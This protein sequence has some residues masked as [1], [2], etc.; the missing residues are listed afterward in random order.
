[1]KK[2]LAA[3]LF[4]IATPVWAQVDTVSNLSAT[5]KT[6]G[7]TKFWSEAKYNFVY[8]DKTKINWDSAYTAYLPQVLATKS[9][10]DY[11]NVLKKFCALLQ[12]GHTNVF[13]P[14]NLYKTSR[15]RQ[16]LIENFDQHFFVTNVGKESSAKEIIGSEVISINNQP[17]QIWLKN[18]II[19]YISASTEHQRWN[20]A[21]RM[22]FVDTDTTKTWQLKLKTLKGKQID[23]QANWHTY[24]QNWYQPIPQW[25]RFQYKKIGDVGYLQINTFADTAI[26]GD[27]RKVL[28]ELYTC[29]AIIIDLRKN[30][31]GNS[32]IGADLLK[33]FTTEKNIVGSVWKTRD[34][35]AAFNAWG[36]AVLASNPQ[37]DI[38]T[39]SNFR[40]KSVQVAQGNYWFQ[41]DTMQFENNLAVKR[42]EQPLVVL[43]SNNTASAAE[44][45]L[46]MLSSLNG[47]ATTIGQKS[48]GST[49][50]PL[51]IDLPGGGSARIC[52]KR[53]TY[54]D[55]KEFVGYGIKPDLEVKRKVQDAIS[56]EDSELK[57]ALSKLKRET[58]AL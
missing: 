12:D 29:K 46:I 41:G 10:W 16:I 37:V 54:P 5:E 58:K 2:L 43:Q 44:D 38:N 8:F 7:L 52:A 33:Y 49:G 26:L 22:L 3:L 19:P 45:F 56:G 24:R 15:Y 4:A 9:T 13:E 11:Y 48:F 21:A 20:D 14:N 51:F 32:Q 18:N 34:H 40:K 39:L 31:G 23:Y 55:G 28:P 50:Q 1:M 36:K 47:R 6:W 30:G 35:Q 25:E 42:L 27:F 53:D 17:T 57:I